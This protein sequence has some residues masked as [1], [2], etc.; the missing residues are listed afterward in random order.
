MRI[1]TVM[2]PK[3]SFPTSALIGQ[4]VPLL[5]V[6]HAGQPLRCYRCDSYQHRIAQCPKPSLYRR[7]YT[8]GF[9]DH[10]HNHCPGNIN[11]SS[12]VTA[13]ELLEDVVHPEATGNNAATQV[14]SMTENV[15]T[16]ADDMNEAN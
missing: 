13:T 11:R 2:E 10:L 6:R 4:Y 16:K 5:F 8:C 14:S 12:I 7:C 9:E 15:E 3:G 1:F